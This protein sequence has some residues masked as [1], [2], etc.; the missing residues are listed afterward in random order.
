LESVAGL[1]EKPVREETCLERLLL[2]ALAGRASNVS[3]PDLFPEL[4]DGGRPLAADLSVD[5][6]LVPKLLDLRG[7]QFDGVIHLGRTMNRESEYL[8]SGGERSLANYYTA[9]QSQTTLD[10]DLGQNIIFFT[11]NLATDGPINRFQA[12]VC[13]DV[14]PYFRRATRDRI[15]A[16][17]LYSLVRLGFLCLGRRG[18]MD[19]GPFEGR[20][21]EFCVEQKS[22]QRVK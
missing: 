19:D 3:R 7:C 20:Y 1:R 10:P 2:K 5:Q 22:Y 9:S 13:R 8:Q 18:L 6:D 14:L 4:P 16:L 17:F 12:I 21:R 11:H 15:Q